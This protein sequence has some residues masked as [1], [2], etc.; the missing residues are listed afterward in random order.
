MTYLAKGRSCYLPV[1]FPLVE[2]C[3]YDIVS[4]ILENLIDQCRLGE[5]LAR[6]E[7]RLWKKRSIDSDSS[8]WP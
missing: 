3:R 1:P 8:E 6:V 7:Y 2:F 4:E 5:F